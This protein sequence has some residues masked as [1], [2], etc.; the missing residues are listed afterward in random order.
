[1]VEPDRARP[2]R[3]RICNYVSHVLNA[4]AVVSAVLHIAG[5]KL[6]TSHPLM[7]KRPSKP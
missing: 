4:L 3:F 1:M 5:A 7:L 6:E 2:G